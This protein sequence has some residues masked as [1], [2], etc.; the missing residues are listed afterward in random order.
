MTQIADNCNVRTVKCGSRKK[1]SIIRSPSALDMCGVGGRMPS[2]AIMTRYEVPSESGVRA[3]SS[4]LESS[5]QF[6]IEVK[7]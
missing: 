3:S 1:H 5:K 6:I 4:E 2:S 7:G